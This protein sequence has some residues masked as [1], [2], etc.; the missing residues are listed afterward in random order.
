M[1]IATRVPTDRW[2]GR[3]V[4]TTGL[5]VAVAT[6]GVV[7]QAA[8]VAMPGLLVGVTAQDA[9]G[10]ATGDATGE[11]AEDL[12]F[13]DELAKDFRRGGSYSAKREL[14]EYL[15]DYPE[16]PRARQLAA[17]AALTRGDLDEVEAHL[18]VVT[19]PAPALLAA[20]LLRRGQYEQALELAADGG[21][22]EVAA[23]RL[24]VAA[25]DGL[26]R[27]REAL[28]RA[29]QAT[30]AI[31]DRALDGQGLVDLAW[32][33]MMQRKF[34]VANQALVFADAELNG[35][36]GPTYRLS[37][38]SVIVMLGEVY[39]ATRQS[40]QG[41][42]DK[43]LAALNE[44][45]A[46]DSGHADALTVK[47]KVYR[48]GGNG[49][50]A[51]KALDRALSRDPGHPGA[52]VLRG[53]MMLQSRRIDETILVADRVLADNPRHKGGL[54]L[55]ASALAVSRRQED[56]AAARVLFEEMHPESSALDAL[57]GRVFQEHYRF[58][59]SVGPLE[60][61]L[62][63]EP[64]NEDPLSVLGQSL[65]HLGREEEA[66][67]A[68][69][70]H[71]ERSPY[72]FPWRENMLEV[73]RRLAEL[74]EIETGD[75]F[76]IRLPA[77][78]QQVLGV[79]LPEVLA[80]AR[81]D[82]AARWGYDPQAE[83]LIEVFD[84][85]ADFSA[86][87]VGF[88]GFFAVGACFGNVVT[89]VSPLSEMRRRFHWVQTA[90][91]EYAHVVTLGLSRQRLPR[92]LSEGISVVEEHKLNP[93]WT[94]PLERDVLEARANDR[95]FPV[96]RLDEAFQDGSTVMLG[97]YLGSLV[98]EVVERDFGFPKLV[99]MVAAYGDGSTTR[100]V[101]QAVLGVEPEE[102]DARLL[103]YIDTVIAGRASIRPRLG[104]RAKDILRER[105][106]QGDDEAL[107]ELAWAY[108][109]LG[110]DVD[111]DSTLRRARQKLG[112][113]PTITR[114]EADIDWRADRFDPARAKLQEL[115][116]A[117]LLEA[118]G[119]V[120]LGRL[121][122]LVGERDAALDVLRRA[123]ALFPGDISE[124]GALVVLY[125]QLDQDDEAERVE[126][127]DVVRATCRYD[128]TAV[129]PRRLLAREA[130]DRDD[131][132]TALR[133]YQEIVAIDPYAPNPRMQLAQVYSD[134]GRDEDAR[135]QWTFVLGMRSDQVP[136]G[137]RGG[138][139][140][141]GLVGE[142]LEKM[143]ERARRRLAGDE[144]PDR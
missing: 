118:D 5:A 7:G 38:P 83:V 57:L 79:L 42:L 114:L 69:E 15:L 33:Y 105:A 127:L 128:D 41:G 81:S 24:G 106:M 72:P 117:D 51:T 126:W 40:G 74:T 116:D 8:V 119:L 112:D 43:T 90:V 58:A 14:D 54:A 140:L 28:T 73:L 37:E 59:E 107:V 80:E 17:E 1:V 35:K 29:T 20:V 97:Y 139:P 87:T 12:A 31:D 65:A 13:L 44:V 3:A 67:A 142:D 84:V 16:S 61:A 134:M 55:R 122:L 110:Q 10:D 78:E 120:Q 143:Q 47:A 133:M 62:A 124:Q 89:L 132:D 32:L 100:E 82:L 39:H 27:R 45:L 48:Y 23:A 75:D 96:T 137:E 56:S 6:G 129:E 77:G 95:I 104:V 109:D 136:S 99:E 71:R 21:L 86:R 50:A 135:R 19:D 98:C 25:L 93:E 53:E 121:L 88:E 46:V 68:L 92:W 94:R 2:Y 26:G 11:T 36:R 34:E 66:R 70:E 85:H 49:R 141:A 111:R 115:A 63:I 144:D 131:I 123:R 108:H 113:S 60:R 4:R 76:R 138:G 102:L 64:D 9:A 18:A 22:S 125:E 101:V 91:H 30:N 52:L 103:I 130:L